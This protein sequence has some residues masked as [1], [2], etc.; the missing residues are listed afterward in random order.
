MLSVSVSVSV[1]LS[2]SL[3]LSHTH[4]HSLTLHRCRNVTYKPGHVVEHCRSSYTAERRRL[5][6]CQM[7]PGAAA[8]ADSSRKQVYHRT[9][10]VVPDR[11]NKPQ[12]SQPDTYA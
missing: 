4:T 1:C 5:T 3:S 11:R 2:L 9:S 6:E 7:R 8:E 12:L 10:T